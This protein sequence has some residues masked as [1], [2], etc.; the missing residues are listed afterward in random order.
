[1]SPSPSV[2]LIATDLDG[3]LLLPDKT[4]SA[5]SRA[6]LR[7]AAQ[8]G[9]TL[10]AATGRQLRH[11]PVDLIDLGFHYAIGANGAIG[12]DLADN[13]VI[14][15]ETIS[16]DALQ[17]LSELLRHRVPQVRFAASRNFG[18]YHLC[19]PGYLEL[20]PEHEIL[21]PN[22]RTEIVGLAELL[23]EPTIKVTLRH[24][25]LTPVEL[26]AIVQALG[27]A[28][29]SVTISGAPFVEI[30]SAQATK[31][32]AIARI[33]QSLEIPAASVMAIGDSLNDIDM[34][35]WAGHGVA[36]GNA[37][38]ALRGIADRTTTT[39]IADGF[40]LAVENVLLEGDHT[41]NRSVTLS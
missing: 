7:A 4:V 29:L 38:P 12:V 5:R 20:V 16:T 17:T 15:A 31:A 39:N 19:E 27:V 23:A 26:L 10:L 25:E 22:W 28:G 35:T 21:P 34:V 13:T 36:M 11:V 40:A 1:M 32:T 6:S 3:T 14:F 8:A 2:R 18:E 30:G 9:M 37:D 24:P 33:C 41:W